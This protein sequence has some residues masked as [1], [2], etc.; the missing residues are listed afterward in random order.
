MKKIIPII[1]IVSLAFG[2]LFYLSDI[3]FQLE[4]FNWKLWLV[5]VLFMLVIGALG[6]FVV[7]R[8]GKRSNKE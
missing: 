8:H 7:Y 6:G 3:S 5:E 2:T 1:L 4:M